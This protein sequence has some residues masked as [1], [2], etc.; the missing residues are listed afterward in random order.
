LRG[1]GDAAFKLVASLLHS[2]LYLHHR[3][4]AAW[5]NFRHELK[6]ASSAVDETLMEVWRAL[7]F[8]MKGDV[9]SFDERGYFTCLKLLIYAS[10]VRQQP[11]LISEGCGYGLG[12]NPSLLY[13]S[14]PSRLTFY[15]SDL[16]SITPNL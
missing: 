9:E 13:L 1:S 7:R 10:L 8:S 4:I 16:H 11:H 2:S 5:T 12:Q 14:R 3:L 6:C 15:V